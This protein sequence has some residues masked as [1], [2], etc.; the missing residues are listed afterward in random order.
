MLSKYQLWG[1]KKVLPLSANTAT[2][3]EYVMRVSGKK[4]DNKP[5]FYLKIT[6][7]NNAVPFITLSFVSKILTQVYKHDCINTDPHIYS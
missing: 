7:T 6:L 1:N 5:V 2:E 3:L 4:R